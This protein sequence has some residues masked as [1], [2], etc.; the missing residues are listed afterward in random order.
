MVTNEENVDEDEEAALRFTFDNMPKDIRLGFGVGCDPRLSD[1]F[2]GYQEEHYLIAALTSIFT[3]D[4]RGRLFYQHVTDQCSSKVQYDHQP[5]NPRTHFK[6]YLMEE[7]DHLQIT[8]A[9]KFQ[10]LVKLPQHGDNRAEYR[11]NVASFLQK[12]R[13]ASRSFETSTLS[14]PST[15]ASP[16]HTTSSDGN[17][18]YYFRCPGRELGRGAYG[19][20]FV[21]KDVSSGR[22]LA[23]KT[24][25][26]SNPSREAKLLRSLSH[27]NIVRYVGQPSEV[28]PM[29]V[30]EY[31]RF[32]SLNYQ[33]GEEPLSPKEIIT[34]LYQSLRGLAHLQ[35]IRPQPLVHRDIKPHNI[36]IKYREKGRIWIKLA[37]FGAARYGNKIVGRTG[38]L[39]YMAPEQFSRSSYNALVDIWSLGVTMLKCL[40]GGL[41]PARKESEQS[42]SLWTTDIVLCI[43]ARNKKYITE[44]RLGSDPKDKLRRQICQFLAANMLVID[45]QERSSAARCLKTGSSTIFAN[46]IAK[47][48][49]NDT[50][51]LVEH[52]YTDDDSDEDLDEEIGQLG[53]DILVEDAHSEDGEVDTEQ[54]TLRRNEIE[55]RH[56]SEH[57]PRGPQYVTPA[58]KKA[59]DEG[60]SAHQGADPAAAAAVHQEGGS[61]NEHRPVA[62]SDDQPAPAVRHTC[63]PPQAKRPVPPSPMGGDAKRR[64]VAEDEEKTS[65]GTTASALKAVRKAMSTARKPRREPAPTDARVTQSKF[66]E[67]DKKHVQM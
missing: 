61:R 35:T 14:A 63:P 18:P 60:K 13:D 2:C 40:P 58:D 30:M 65:S 31:C 20:V 38:T 54:T 3:F 29:L 37:D 36:L 59:Q 8:I 50:S 17:K 15:S 23:A 22:R 10:F 27:E 32:G 57:L 41:P 47:A 46:N 39:A 19:R 56:A 53:P 12:R 26:N 1:V 51:S 44:A 55:Q 4:E 49:L 28:K 45:S 9:K 66:R 34:V 6:W 7:C 42:P 24:L 62:I 11:R 48:Q 33:M 25:K 43:Q 64:K 21:V 52:S 67:S 5:V 16:M